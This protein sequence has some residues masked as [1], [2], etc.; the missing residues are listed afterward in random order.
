MAEPGVGLRERKKH[1]TR[2]EISDVAT[3]LFERDGFETVTLAQIANAADV[4]VKTIFNYFGSKEDLYF[5][6][7]AEL[8]NS[9]VS[10]VRDR[11]AG[12][13]VLDALHV[14]MRDNAMP[15]RGSGWAWLESPRALR[16][17]RR[18][19]AV[20]DR[21][22]AL[23]ARRLVIAEELGDDL[24]EAV[25]EEVGRPAEALALRSL[26][27]ALVATLGLRD[28][29]VRES[30]REEVPVGELRARVVAAVDEAFRRL[31]AAYADIDPP[32]A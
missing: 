16:E 31:R 4:S 23:A 30:L 22:P 26:R 19:I 25:A 6:R 14:L 11:A 12:T 7:A 27:G 3:R 21:S 9:L 32:R 17:V 15:F 20:Q 29:V 1:R 8:R 18:F 24:I 10:T 28:R 2:R 5:D 13:S